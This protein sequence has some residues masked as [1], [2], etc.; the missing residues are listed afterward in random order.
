MLIF[1]KA[2]NSA[3]LEMRAFLVSLPA[4]LLRQYLVDELHSIE[5]RVDILVPQVL[6]EF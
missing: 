1:V 4:P 5:N 2:N 6:D 3:Y